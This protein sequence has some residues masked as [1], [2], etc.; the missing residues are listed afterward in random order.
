MGVDWVPGDECVQGGTEKWRGDS[1]EGRRVD[2]RGGR[3]GRGDR[4]GIQDNHF[5]Q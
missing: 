1:G 2:G 3:D 5:R 4:E